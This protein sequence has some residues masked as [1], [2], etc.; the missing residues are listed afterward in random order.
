MM[1]ITGSMPLVAVRPGANK[2]TVVAMNTKKML[3]SAENTKKSEV[4]I[5]KQKEETSR[6]KS[7]QD[8]SSQK[9]NNEPSF[10][11]FIRSRES[12]P[13]EP[14]IQQPPISFGEQLKVLASIS[15]KDKL[16]QKAG[17]KVMSRNSK[18]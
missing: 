9:G 7:E 13:Y 11:S 16:N 3:I 17:I 15:L 2:K 1:H 14:Y 6:K 5:N 18:M 4:K 8:L 12:K 10:E